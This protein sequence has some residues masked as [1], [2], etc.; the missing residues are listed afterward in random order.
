[1]LLVKM[2]RN[3]QQMREKNLSSP[4]KPEPPK[5]AEKKAE[6]PKIEPEPVAA[7]EPVKKAD[8]EEPA[9]KQG[10]DQVTFDFEGN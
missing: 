3:L 7:K 1:M 9:P 8:S 5:P 4:E 6:S 2:E 10:K